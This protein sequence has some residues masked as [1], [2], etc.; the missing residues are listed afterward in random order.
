MITSGL[1]QRR[2]AGNHFGFPFQERPSKSIEI[3]PSF[4]NT[5]DDMV[6]APSVWADPQPKPLQTI[7]QDIKYDD[8]FGK[9]LSPDERF[10]LYTQNMTRKSP[11]LGTPV[12]TPSTPY[13]GG[14]GR[15]PPPA[16]GPP[17][18]GGPPPQPTGSMPSPMPPQNG[19]PP[20]AGTSPYG[21]TADG[22]TPI[23]PTLETE[24]A[25][26][27]FVDDIGIAARIGARVTKAAIGAR[28]K[29]LRMG[30]DGLKSMVLSDKTKF[31]TL[32]NLAL[33]SEY[34]KRVNYVVNNY[35][36]LQKEME[37]A[38]QSNIVIPAAQ[39]ARNIVLGRGDPVIDQES[40]LKAVQNQWN[41]HLSSL[42]L[43]VGPERFQTFI[44]QQVRQ[45]NQAGSQL[46]F[47]ASLG[48]LTVVVTVL[49]DSLFESAFR[50]MGVPQPMIEAAQE[51]R[52]SARIAAQGAIN[53][54]E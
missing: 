35:H 49:I 33:P 48:V 43:D 30:Y 13:G 44:K 46:M 40:V 45:V 23:N 7:P 36:K 19:M 26:Q 37:Q 25:A 50:A 17:S 4:N 53:Y 2:S 22:Y 14:P 51:L 54:A 41:E 6:V 16:G 18:V 12:G 28:N 38:F 52:R 29:I 8:I 47:E 24:E 27:E 20:Q 31:N 15:L 3:R 9:T 34:A 5:P 32:V 10:L 42:L 11:A 21:T 39:N 1:V